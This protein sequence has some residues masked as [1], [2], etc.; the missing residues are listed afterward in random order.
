MLAI[1]GV[2]WWI[3]PAI[4]FQDDKMFSIAFVLIFLPI[5]FFTLISGILFMV[6]S[7]KSKVS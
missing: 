6:A 7:R 5:G 4:L 1:L 3:I 2:L